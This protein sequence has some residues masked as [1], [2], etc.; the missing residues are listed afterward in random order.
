MPAMRLRI[1]A[2]YRWPKTDK[3]GLA[4]APQGDSDKLRSPANSLAANRLMRFHDQQICPI[5]FCR[6]PACLFQ[7]HIARATLAAT[8]REAHTAAAGRQRYRR[9]GAFICRTPQRALGEAGGGG[10]PARA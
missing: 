2:R 4:L 1:V 5:V 3:R 6:D 7:R 10:E 9:Y 8:R